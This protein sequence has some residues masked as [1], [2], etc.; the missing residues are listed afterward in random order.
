MASTE[1]LSLDNRH[2]TSH[3]TMLVLYV[4]CRP[5]QELLHVH[6]CLR[7]CPVQQACQLA[8]HTCKL[9][10][11]ARRDLQP[12]LC[13]LLVLIHRCQRQPQC[14]TACLGFTILM[15]SCCASEP[16]QLQVDLCEVQIVNVTLCLLAPGLL[17]CWAALARP[18][19]LH[20]HCLLLKIY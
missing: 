17:A 5:L 9:E 6:A 12:L 8:R 3:V 11:A 4:C 20:T 2:E 18:P 16:L 13:L 10:A 7:E 19:P 14:L 1:K 15:P